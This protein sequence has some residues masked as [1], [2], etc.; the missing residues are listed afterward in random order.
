MAYTKQV[1]PNDATQGGATPARMNNI[2]Q[3]I[4]DSLQ[5]DR[6]ITWGTAAPATG[7]RVRGAIHFNTQPTAGG[8]FGW[9]CVTA[10]TPG[11]WKEMG[12]L[13]A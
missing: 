11:T 5:P 8:P 9:M 13:E 12:T 6:P 1:W 2:E 4:A 3:G 10:G 7:S